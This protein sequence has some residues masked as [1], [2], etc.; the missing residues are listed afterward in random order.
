MPNPE[1]FTPHRQ[2]RIEDDLWDQFGALVG[3]RER[4]ADL[5]AYIQWRVANPG[6]DLT[7]A[8]PEQ[9]LDFLLRI[10]LV[11]DKRRA[12]IMTLPGTH[13]RNA[14]ELKAEILT[15]IA[16]HFKPADGAEDQPVKA[17]VKR[18]RKAPK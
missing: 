7:V 6:V 15:L 4:S 13:G 10:R 3:A 2:V 12:E 8:T 1:N 9:V 11:G 17:P 18:I 14:E 16:E 5:K